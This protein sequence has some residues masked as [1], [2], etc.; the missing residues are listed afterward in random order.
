MR[1]PANADLAAFHKIDASSA[2]LDAHVTAAAQDGFHLAL[3]DLDA[4]RSGDADGF[5][6]DDAHGIG[7]W[8][9]GARSGCG[10]K[11]STEDG[12]AG[13]G[14]RGATPARDR[15]GDGGHRRGDTPTHGR[16]ESRLY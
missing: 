13:C 1:G 4:H 7:K 5:A 16:W 9:V 8:L 6:F 12:Q 10:D 11:R 15:I 2:G 3:D 14:K